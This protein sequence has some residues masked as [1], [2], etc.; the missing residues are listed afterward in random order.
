MSDPRLESVW[1][2]TDPRWGRMA[3]VLEHTARVHCPDWI[4]SVIPVMVD[5]V[6]AGPVAQAIV[7][8]VENT[9]KLDHWN[10][11]IQASDLGD[12]ILLIDADTFITAP[13]DDVWEMPFDI[14]YTVRSWRYPINGGVMFLRVSHAVQRFFAAW[15]A[16]NR[17]MLTDPA[18]HAPYYARYTGI[19]QAS[20]GALL[21]RE[22]ELEMLALPCREWNCEDSAWSGFDETTRIVHVKGDL[23]RQVFSKNRLSKGAAVD[24]LAALWHR[25]DAATRAQ[26]A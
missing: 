5:P 21:E 15:A 18:L 26:V 25:L 20:F 1:F 6:P 24:R 14:A 3:A 9:Q 8:L 11:A 2:G 12:Q 19:N 22:T 10:A 16:L 7:G 13:L 4:V 23:R 17:A